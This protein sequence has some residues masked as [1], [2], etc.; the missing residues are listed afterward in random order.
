MND[1]ISQDCS[2]SHITTNMNKASSSNYGNEVT[3][4]LNLYDHHNESTRVRK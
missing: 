3:E 1:L 2:C 4:N